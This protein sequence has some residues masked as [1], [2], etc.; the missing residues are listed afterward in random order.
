MEKKG[1]LRTL[2]QRHQPTDDNTQLS[3]HITAYK[4]RQRESSGKGKAAG[5]NLKDGTM[6]AEAS[7]DITMTRATV[8]GPLRQYRV[9]NISA[10]THHALCVTRCSILLQASF[11]AQCAA[12]VLT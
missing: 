5:Q 11:R 4:F 2:Q 12:S 8:V 6:L 7:S 10:G 9:V 3:S 1:W